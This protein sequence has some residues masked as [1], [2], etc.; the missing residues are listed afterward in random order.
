MKKS[1]TAFISVILIIS[2]LFCAFAVEPDGF[3]TESAGSGKVRISSV[4]SSV[5]GDVT[6]PS[7]IDGKTVIGIGKNAFNLNRGITSL[8]L[9][10][11]ITDAGEKAFSNM[12]VY[13]VI[14]SGSGNVKL[15]SYL[16]SDSRNITE[17]VLP[18][19]TEAIPLGCFSGC[20]SLKTFSLPSAVK[21]IG[22]N[23]FLNCSS[24]EC[25]SFPASVETINA[26]AFVQCNSIKRYEVDSSNRFFRSVDGVLYS[27]DGKKLIAYPAAKEDVSFSVPEGVEEIEMC[28]FSGNRFVTEI[29]LSSTVKS[30]G[31]Y[32]FHF[33]SSLF[34][35]NFNDGLETL[36]TYI[37]DHSPKMRVVTIPGTL[38][39]WE[40][41]FY[42]SQIEY[43]T[44]SEGIKSI[45]K[46]AF[47]DCASLKSVKIPSSLE[48]IKMAAFMG[49]SSLEQLTLP[50]SFKSA[51]ST[52]FSGSDVVIGANKVT[53]TSD[54]LTLKAGDAKL[55]EFTVLPS[56][57]NEAISFASGD[58]S[59]A[60]VSP[61]GVV[62]A[63]KP[64]TADITV[65]SA[66]GRNLGR[67]RVTVLDNVVSSAVFP[68]DISI[69]Y[70]E[71]RTVSCS[72]LP[73]SASDKAVTY[74]ID[75][76]SIAYVSQDGRVLGLD[77]GETTL[78][79]F[80]SKGAE[81]GNCKVKVSMN[82]WQKILKFFRDIF[83]ISLV[84]KH[85]G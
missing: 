73:D 37:F 49:C 9:P 3:V 72:F 7:E 13:S 74:R 16:F 70:D 19:G 44:V 55:L 45:D 27:A 32:A 66:S 1:F 77:E 58:S 24:I 28:A 41:A 65:S 67:V 48:T 47:R 79:V 76:E 31:N 57:S 68:S 59:V 12:S 25:I 71:I 62:T 34:K 20:S 18:S 80:N 82:L 56:C 14:F 21:S 64:G 6:V 78:R 51:D 22:Q 29:T 81:I 2:V 84:K 75:R 8:N 60:A 54:E 52:A 17:V 50:D 42:S 61:V 5:S 40:S 38:T 69:S 26:P 35:V 36:G 83:K 53:F 11:T 23:A 15:G 10:S 4:G 63:N 85:F 43:V 33:C 30:V 46:M 39:S